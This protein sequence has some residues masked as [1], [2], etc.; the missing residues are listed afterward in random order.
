MRG[1]TK[2]ALEAMLNYNPET[3]VFT[4]RVNRRPR[5]KI[6]KVAGYDNGSGYVKIGINGK[7]EYAHRLAF[8]MMT[9]NQIP[10]GAVVDHIN[11]NSLDNR[12]VNLRLVTQVENIA[13]TVGAKNIRRRES[14]KWEVRY[15]EKFYGSFAT[16]EQARDQAA[17]IRAAFALVD[18][19]LVRA[20]QSFPSKVDGG[21]SFIRRTH[22]G[23]SLN[24]VAKESG[25]KQQ[26]LY[27]YA[28]TKKMGIP[29]ALE[30]IKR[31]TKY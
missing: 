23:K 4:W 18:P 5:A 24:A 9:G 12:W 25:I 20:G 6:G 27:Y 13:N 7:R 17:K 1:H 15:A 26:M 3:G 22:D 10:K 2:Q 11:G 19:V 28:V 29:D 8:I 14:G 21:Y 31:M 16:E 30:H